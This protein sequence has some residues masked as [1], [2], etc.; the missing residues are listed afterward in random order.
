MKKETAY[1]EDWFVDGT[2]MGNFIY[3]GDTP[4]K[5]GDHRAFIC[6]KV[7]AK[8]LGIK[9]APRLPARILLEASLRPIKKGV[10]FI[11]GKSLGEFGETAI[12][13]AGTKKNLGTYPMAAKPLREMV[14]ADRF[15]HPTKTFTF[16]LRITDLSAKTKP[17][18]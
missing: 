13:Y 16:Y 4:D 7:V 2:E 9:S 15:E 10:K 1:K 3:K 5:D 8:L 14:G 6:A 17:S 18:K 12:R 11:A